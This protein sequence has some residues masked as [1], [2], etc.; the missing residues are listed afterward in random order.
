MNESSWNGIAPVVQGSFKGVLA[1]FLLDLGFIAQ[2]QLGEAWK[3]KATAIFVAIL[4][5]LFFGLIALFMS[6]WVGVSQG[7]QILLAV[8]VGS[9]SYIAAPAAVRSSIPQNS[10]GVNVNW[11]GAGAKSAIVCFTN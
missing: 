1:F 4:S 6:S 5:P 2:K 3:F 10:L 9:A 7:D 8:L 11:P